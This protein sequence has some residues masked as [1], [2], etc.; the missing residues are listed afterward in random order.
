[1][2]GDGVND[3][4]ALKHAHVGVAM[5][6]KGTDVARESADIII[7]DDNFASIVSGIEEGRTVY[8]NIRKIVFF[9]ISTSIAEVCMFL[10][11]IALAL[12]VPLFATQLLWLNFATSIIQDIAL[13]FDPPEGD[14]LKRPP[15]NPKDSIFDSLMKTRIL[16]TAATMGSIAFAEFYWMLNFGGYSVDDARNLILLQFVLFENVIV[17]NSQSETQSF[18]SRPLMRN[19]L[20]IYG[21]LAAQAM[22]IAAMFTP[23]LSD[24]LLIHPVTMQEWAILL[25][26]ALVLMAVIE[27]EKWV[28]RKRDAIT[29]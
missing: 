3:A 14:E 12:P 6:L 1:M 15:R 19:P 29:A 18:F 16:I 7:T 28:R 23:G 26:I 5:A 17:L 10:G 9:L 2:T 8:G 20:L 21:T 13:A 25:G 11:A 22:H 24:V 27:L 4:P